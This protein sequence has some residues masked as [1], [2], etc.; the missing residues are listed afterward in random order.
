[1]TMSQPS[2]DRPP[3]ESKKEIS[4]RRKDRGCVSVMKCPRGMNTYA[5]HCI[6]SFLEENKTQRLTINSSTPKMVRMSPFR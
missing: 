4:S 2:G 3:K 5:S 1:M 6:Y